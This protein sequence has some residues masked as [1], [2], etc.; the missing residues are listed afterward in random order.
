MGFLALGWF[1]STGFAPCAVAPE[2]GGRWC[3]VGAGHSGDLAPGL[4]GW[5]MMLGAALGVLDLRDVPGEI[6]AETGV[7]PH[8]I[9]PSVN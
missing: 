3:W 1:C 2:E 7:F 4:P 9:L 5:E 8:N 6:S